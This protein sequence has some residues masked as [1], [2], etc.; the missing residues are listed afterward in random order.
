MGASINSTAMAAHACHS[1][2]PPRHLPHYSPLIQPH[3]P[4]LTTR[5][6]AGANP[7][8]PYQLFH[9]IS[10]FRHRR[11]QH[12]RCHSYPHHNHPHQVQQ[13][14]RRHP[15][16][17]QQQAPRQ[18]RPPHQQQIQATKS[19]M[20]LCKPLNTGTEPAQMHTGHSTHNAKQNSRT[21]RCHSSP[22]GI[23][24][25]QL[26]IILAS[27]CSSRTRPT[28]HM[29]QTCQRSSVHRRASRNVASTSHRP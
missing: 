16:P 27:I 1:R 13:G 5:T 14:H 24:T 2:Q 20:I 21:S 6:H 4:A 15:Y 22:F 19:H 10:I 29:Q 17:P 3:K 11:H 18:Q 23:F 9:L 7:R 8:Y 12:L 26:V 28:Y 25:P